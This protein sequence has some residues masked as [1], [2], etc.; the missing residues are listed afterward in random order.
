MV[1]DVR[2]RPVRTLQAGQVFSLPVEADSSLVWDQEY[3]PW[4]FPSFD[5]VWEEFFVSV[6]ANGTLTVDVRPQAGSIAGLVECRYVGCPSWRVESSVSIFVEARW[7][8]LYFNVQVP[9]SSAPQR[10]DIHTSFR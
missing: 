3:D 2:L 6:P 10:Y 9:R 7:S 5:S 1:Q 8:P 4:T